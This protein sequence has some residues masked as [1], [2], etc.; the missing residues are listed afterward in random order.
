MRRLPGGGRAGKRTGNYERGEDATAE[1]KT[2][3]GSHSPRRRSFLNGKLNLPRVA[4]VL[5]NGDVIFKRDAA[6]IATRV[7]FFSFLR[8]KNV[9][10]KCAPSRPVGGL[11]ESWEREGE[12]GVWRIAF[13]F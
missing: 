2:P 12:R 5:S 3:A 11:S 4:G 9:F 13:Y 1:T 6:G 7:F 10:G 8:G